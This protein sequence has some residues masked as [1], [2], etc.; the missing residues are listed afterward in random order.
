M[1]APSEGAV[2][3]FSQ[4]LDFEGRRRCRHGCDCRRPARAMIA[5]ASHRR[6]GQA[7]LKEA[8][9]AFPDSRRW[10]TRFA[11]PVSVPRRDTPSFRGVA[12]LG[13]P[14]VPLVQPLQSVAGTGRTHAGHTETW[15]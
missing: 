7:G 6:E 8:L 5:P 2:I 12:T 3:G 10:E 13:A 15:A 11:P 4:A 1:A 14:T 9:P